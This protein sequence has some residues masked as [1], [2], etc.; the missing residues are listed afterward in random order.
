MVNYY[1]SISLYI[2]KLVGINASTKFKLFPNIFVV[3]QTIIFTTSRNFMS[4]KN[5]ATRLHVQN[6]I[7]NCIG[8]MVYRQKFIPVSV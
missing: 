7:E 5:F 1:A 6:V 2:Y 3:F 4:T 8:S